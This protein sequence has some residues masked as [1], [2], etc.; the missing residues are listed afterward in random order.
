[1]QN[2]I[3]YKINSVFNSE[4]TYISNLI[5][6]QAEDLSFK[7]DSSLLTSRPFHQCWNQVSFMEKNKNKKDHVQQF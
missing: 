2:E 3:I 6:A 7:R 4:S 5:I 1:M